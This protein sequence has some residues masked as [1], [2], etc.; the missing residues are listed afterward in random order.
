MLQRDEFKIFLRVTNPFIF[1]INESNKKN[2]KI[3]YSKTILCAFWGNIGKGIS[4]KHSRKMII[5]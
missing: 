5:S 3:P 2:K 4:I 1:E